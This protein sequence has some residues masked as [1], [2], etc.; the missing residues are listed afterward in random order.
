MSDR[1]HTP[2]PH[3]SPDQFGPILRGGRG[4]RR[5]GPDWRRIGVVGVV[6]L[7]IL[8]LGVV[9]TGAALLWYG[10]RAITRVDVDVDDADEPPPGIEVVSEVLNILVVGNDSR[11]GL[12]R[13]QLLRLG[14]EDH[15]GT[16]TDT[17]MLVQLDP[18]REVIAVLS[19]PR[20]LY[21]TRCDGSRGRINAAFG[22]G[23]RSGVGGGNCLVQTV[24]D[25]T[26]IPIH[27]YVQVNFAGFVDV[28]DT[29][30]G[31]TMYFEE[32]LR[33]RFAGLDISAG[34]VELDGIRA[35]TFVRSRHLD[36]DFGRIARQQRFLRE[37][38]DEVTRAGVLLN[39]PRLFSL[40]DAVGRAIET[41]QDL[42]LGDMRR[43]AFSLRNV[44]PE[45]LD[46]RTVPSVSR[47]IGGGSYVVAKEEQAETLF[48]AFRRGT[49]APEG[50]GTDPPGALEPSDVPAFAVLNGVGTAGA[51]AAV[52]EHLEARGFE[53]AE[54][55]NAPSWDFTETMVFHPPGALEEAELLAAH[56]GTARL[57]ATDDEDD[58]IQVVIGADF[59]PDALAAAGPDAPGDS[60]GDSPGDSPGDSQG[61]RPGA[62]PEP[63]PDPTPRFAGAASQDDRC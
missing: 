52:Q 22:T 25:F 33:D 43:I 19:F 44:G 6:G 41:D 57:V 39:V 12:T 13:E 18:D 30:G 1:G 10:N 23:V 24:R 11:A 49:I 56:L 17:V 8:L 28:V 27:H 16:L 47:R 15:G 62:T 58:P 55:G 7:L 50:L 26:G 40:V 37:L 63:D 42:S 34:C 59:D 2:P 3:L 4:R 32:P 36:N 31:V 51:A 60:L 45:R 21:V 5:R 54:T 20:D 46:T 48:E 61:E 35:L 29:V 9:G 14:T 38:M 53:V